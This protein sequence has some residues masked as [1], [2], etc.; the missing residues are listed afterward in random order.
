MGDARTRVGAD[1]AV[2]EGSTSSDS[3]GS[4]RGGGHATGTRRVESTRAA[5]TGSSDR[6]ASRDPNEAVKAVSGKVEDRDALLAALKKVDIKDTARG[7]VSVD[8]WGNPV[9]SIY[10]RKVE[11]VGGK[12]QNTVIAT[13]PS[14]GQFYKFNPDEY[15][16][17]PLYSRDYPPCKAC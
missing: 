17:L 9:Q 10:V 11:R 15:M 12:L 6:T 3:S 13:I 16:K 14:V 5:K 7:P 1:Y 8:R 4:P 2:A